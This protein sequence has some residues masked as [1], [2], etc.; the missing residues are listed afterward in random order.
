M[1]RD[2]ERAVVFEKSVFILSPFSES[3]ALFHMP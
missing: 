3:E 2:D 1:D